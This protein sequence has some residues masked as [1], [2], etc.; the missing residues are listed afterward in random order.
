M[1]AMHNVEWRSELSVGIPSIDKDHKHLIELTNT[2]IRAID[3]EMPKEDLLDIF[4]ELEAYTHYHFERE[5]HFM[6]THCTSQEMKVQIAKHKEQHKYFCDKLPEL[7]NRLL[8]AAT[9]SVSYEIVEFLLQWLLDHIINEDLKLTHCLEGDQQNGRS[10]V[11][12]VGDKLRKKTTLHQ[13]LW[14]ILSLPLFFF[15]LQTL[16]ISYNA[17]EKYHQLQDVEKIT[18]SVISINNV[19]TQLQKERGLSSAYIS[20]N[21][22]HFRQELLAQRQKTDTVIQQSIHTKDILLPYIN[23]ERGVAA[24]KRLDHIRT[25]IDTER[26]DQQKALAYYSDFID[27]LIGFIK[28]IS[29]LPF[30][31]VDRNTYGP[32]LL[33]LHLNEIHGLIRKEGV[34]CLEKG[35][36]S[37]QSLKELVNKEENY[38]DTFLLLAP[39]ELIKAI[40][41]IETSDNTRRIKAMQTQI[42]T[43]S[44]G[45]NDLAQEWFTA[46][47]QR[48]EAYKKVIEQTLEQ[49]G[50]DASLQKNHF[51]TI[52]TIVWIIFILIVLF[53]GVSI[54]LFKESILHPLDILTNA[55]HKLSAGDK[56]VYFSSV[57]K[58][59]AIGKME[60][61]Y[62]HLRRSLIKADYAN[63]LMELQELK[64][65]KYARL[66]EE[67]PLTGIANRR[68]FMRQLKYE[69]I[70]ANKERRPLT[71]LIL[72]LDRFKQINDTYGHAAG[73]LLLQR[74]VQRTRELIRSSDIF[75]RIGGE[76]FALLLPNTTLEGA[77]ILAEKIVKEIALLDLGDL[78]PGLHMTVSIGVS[79]LE[80]GLEIKE[81]IE[82]ADKNLYEAK[83]RGRNQVCC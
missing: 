53:I 34:T 77:R 28:D 81:F 4:E 13:R 59:D 54:Y 1:S 83:H 40:N 80:E 58:K 33:L 45:G 38:L 21:Y 15:I 14:L 17:Y 12:R 19:I 67:D 9:K 74:F 73:D 71:L 47:S 82:K 27:T 48:I 31:S 78:A 55:L 18:R 30:N 68:A 64:T 7:K 49:M 66:S 62:N 69:M 16:F 29:Y 52:I 26:L 42:I 60:R 44:A 43:K 11:Q 70:Q 3:Q 37:C 20:S 79:E 32:V 65:Q 36:L 75:A 24:L 50:D 39:P 72:D 57:N 22:R 2:L 46:T 25:R 8:L 6:D 56:S 10:W 5:E 63:I 51:S 76:E 41:K 61:A 23:I 35:I